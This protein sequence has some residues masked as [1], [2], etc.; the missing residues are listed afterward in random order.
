[1]AAIGDGFAAAHIVQAVMAGVGS[2]F[3]YPWALASSRKRDGHSI[4]RDWLAS[5]CMFQLT[6]RYRRRMLLGDGRR[7]RRNPRLQH[8]E[9]NCLVTIMAV[10][11]GRF[12][13]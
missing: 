8:K 1:M 6:C 10:G 3:F 2:E 4:V 12:F 13:W 9:D 11:V 7:L 5:A